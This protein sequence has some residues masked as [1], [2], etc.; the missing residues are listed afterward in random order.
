MM[1]GTQTSVIPTSGCLRMSSIG[2]PT[3]APVT[4][5]FTKGCILR[6]WLRKS[7]T[8]RMPAMTAIWEG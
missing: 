2:P 5:S 3:M 8:V 7:A 1:T 4:H 6:N